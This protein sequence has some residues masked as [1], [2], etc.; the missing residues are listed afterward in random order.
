MSWNST[1]QYKK[2][3]KSGAGS[4][5]KINDINK[6]LTWLPKGYMNLLNKISNESGYIGTEAAEI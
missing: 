4:L 2:S 3:M 1:K 5:K 6:P